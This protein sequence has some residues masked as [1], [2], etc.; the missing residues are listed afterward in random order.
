M[1]KYAIIVLV[2]YIFSLFFPTK[3]K[4][5]LR[6]HPNNFSIKREIKTNYIQQMKEYQLQNLW[7]TK[8][9]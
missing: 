1:G 6:F 9:K 7:Q 5:Y 4:S 2:F 3:Q 8:L